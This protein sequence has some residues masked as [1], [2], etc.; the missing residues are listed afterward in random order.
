MFGL[1]LST[2]RDRVRD[3]VPDLLDVGTA[4]DFGAVTAR[5]I[6]WPSAWVVPMAETAG[7][8]QFMQ[9]GVVE[10]RVEVGFAIILAARDIGGDTGARALSE[11]ETLR[12]RIIAA[13]ALFQPLGAS[14]T[15]LHRRGRLVS[16]IGRDG[17]MFWQDEFTVPFQRRITEGAP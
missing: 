2:I 13:M 14:N 17:A 6:R 4:R 3:Q 11:H 8:D 12:P 7:P 15:C 5:T 10:Q 1:Q 9:A 16:S